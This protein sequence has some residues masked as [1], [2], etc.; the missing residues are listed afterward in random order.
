MLDHE[1]R[2]G[3]RMDLARGLETLLVAAAVAALAPVL[4]ALL[5]GPR[6]PQVVVLLAGG[7]LIG[8]QVLGWADRPAIDLLANVGLG[9]LFL[10]AGY[11]LDLRLFREPPGRLAIVAWLVTVALAAA[12]VGVLAAVG[13]VRAFVP[14]ALGLTTTALGTLL[15]I[16]RDNDM[17]GGRFGRYLLAAGAV[18]ELF[19]VLAIALFLGASNKLVALASLVAVGVLAL[20]LS[21]APRLVRG[22]RLERILEEG[23]GSTAQTSIRWTVVLLLLLLV[24]AEEFGLD[25]VLGAFLAG[26]VLRRWAP[27]DVHSLED[28]LDAIGYGFFI[29]LFFVASGMSLDIRSIA[30]APLRLLVFFVL[31][32]AV[33]GVPA[34]FLYRDALP[35]VRRVQ[36]MFLTAT[37]LP[38]LVALAEIGLRNGT[39]LRENAA[40]LVGA[41]ALSV[42]VF[43]MAAVTIERRRR[44]GE[45]PTAAPAAGAPP[46]AD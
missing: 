26:I 46:Q 39:M 43:P 22:N 17:L 10:L 23:E 18:G 37:A 25:V 13:F 19:P 36:M 9:F 35:P 31:L 11:E 15:P 16:L 29:P 2:R 8:P 32:L 20:V 1:S 28:K 14:V 33:R 40:A 27:G 7:V 24:I 44:A 34:L 12:T 5:P 21:F 30:E 42:L 3:S 45:G 6:I 4:V 38:L 41:G